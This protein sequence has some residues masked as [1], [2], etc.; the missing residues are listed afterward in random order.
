MNYRDLEIWKLARELVV[1]IH[2]MTLNDLPK[3]E[4]FEIGSPIRRSMKSVKSNIGEGYGRRQYKQ[5]IIRFIVYAISSNDETIN[6]LETLYETGSLKSTEKYDDLQKRLDILGRK[7]NQF[8]VAIQE[9]H[10]SNK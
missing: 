4:M 1:Y 10:K 8:L 7:L 3:F 9:S 5:E 6:H 2:R